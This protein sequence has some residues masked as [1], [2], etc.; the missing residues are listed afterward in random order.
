MSNDAY[1]SD[2]ERPKSILLILLQVLVSCV[3]VFLVRFQSMSVDGCGNQCD[4]SLL[5]VTVNGIQAVSIVALLVS[6]VIV[7]VRGLRRAPSWWAP[8]GAIVLV[9]IST[10]IAIGLV[11][12]ATI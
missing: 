1:G 3:A 12:L 11:R 2:L 5:T 6:I 7:F 10:A 4:Y 8:L 9:V